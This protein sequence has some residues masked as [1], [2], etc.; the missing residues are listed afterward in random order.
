MMAGP[1]RAG[2]RG[3]GCRA[4]LLPG[5]VE[6]VFME[7]YHGGLQQCLALAVAGLALVALKGNVQLCV[8]STMQNL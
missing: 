4:A 1:G 7:W 2:E 6:L 5:F 3:H 8:E